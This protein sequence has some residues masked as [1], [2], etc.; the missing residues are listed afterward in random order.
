MWLLLA[1]AGGSDS[2]PDIESPS[3]ADL[4][5]DID[6]DPWVV[7]AGTLASGEG[8]NAALTIANLGDENLDL[9]AMTLEEPVAGLTEELLPVP[10]YVV[11]GSELNM[12]FQISP[13]APGAH[14]GVYEVRSND[15]A[16]PLVTVQVL[17]SVSG[18]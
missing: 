2:A 15:P 11:P 8:A 9:T 10:I 7:E 4:G 14:A 12:L 1:C 16:E 6:I 18:G 17:W 13:S 3:A 5:P